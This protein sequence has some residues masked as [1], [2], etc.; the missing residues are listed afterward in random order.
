LLVRFALRCAHGARMLCTGF[1]AAKHPCQNSL[2]KWREKMAQK[3]I[4]SDDTCSS[5]FG[6]SAKFG[7]HL[8]V[9]RV[10]VVL[11][12]VTKR[13]PAVDNVNTTETR[14]TQKHG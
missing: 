14:K 4:A 12:E 13:R 9:F 2:S 10:S 6:T 5:Y 1:F 7:P 8:C 11:L 3:P